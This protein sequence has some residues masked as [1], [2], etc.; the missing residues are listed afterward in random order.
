VRSQPQVGTEV[1]VR[2]PLVPA[3]QVVEAGV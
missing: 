2:L 1:S 3:P